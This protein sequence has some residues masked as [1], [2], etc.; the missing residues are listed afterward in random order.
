MARA[1]MPRARGSGEGPACFS[2]SSEATPWRDSSSDMVSPAGPPPTISTG[3]SIVFV[4]P[5]LRP[6][7]VPRENR[8][9]IT[10][11][12]SEGVRVLVPLGEDVVEPLP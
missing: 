8:N 2:T 10:T 4:A 9:D 5:L 1:W 11:G 6:T 3:T 12:C 7:A